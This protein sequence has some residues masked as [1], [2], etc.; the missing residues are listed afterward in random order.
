M[1]DETA[2]LERALPALDADRKQ[3]L[4]ALCSDLAQQ[5]ARAH[6]DGHHDKW[7]EAADAQAHFTE[8]VRQI[9]ALLGFGG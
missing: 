4:H 5:A 8:D 1:A 2:A 6:H 7:D 3:T 9:E